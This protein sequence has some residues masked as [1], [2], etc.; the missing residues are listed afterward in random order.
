MTLLARRYALGGSTNGV[1]HLLALAK[2]AGVPLVVDDFN[3]IGREIP[4]LANL[5]PSGSYNWA[6]VDELGGLPVVMK[7][8]ADAGLLHTDCLTCTGET[9]A[10]NLEGVGGI[11]S[12]EVQ[13][14]LYQVQEPWSGAG[15]HI[16]VLRESS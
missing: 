1:L 16:S 11:P 14:V 15:N 12:N 13:D 6:D 3:T 10:T 2:E 9:V 4:L 8:L 5:A 7:M